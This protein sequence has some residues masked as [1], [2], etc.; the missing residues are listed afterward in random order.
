MGLMFGGGTLLNTG[1]NIRKSE[2]VPFDTEPWTKFTWSYL[3][4]VNDNSKLSISIQI[5]NERSKF[6]LKKKRLKITLYMHTM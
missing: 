3:Q 2:L 6:D 4:N 5:F 1:R